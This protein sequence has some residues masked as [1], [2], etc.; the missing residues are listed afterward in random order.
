MIDFSIKGY[1][2]GRW[3]RL[4]PKSGEMS[5]PSGTTLGNVLDR[6]DFPAR[7]REALRLFVNGRPRQ[8]DYALQPGDALVF[9]PPLEGG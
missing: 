9:F 7:L 5:V 2:L 3:E 4:L 8:E 6:F 1:S